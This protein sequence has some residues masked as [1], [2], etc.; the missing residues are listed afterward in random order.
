MQDKVKW[1]WY[2][3][4]IIVEPNR[5]PVTR[6]WGQPDVG[7]DPNL[8]KQQK[9]VARDDMVSKEIMNDNG[10]SERYRDGGIEARN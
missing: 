2:M 4:N 10:T 9:K 6:C 5:E 8:M 7:L 1:K 3:R